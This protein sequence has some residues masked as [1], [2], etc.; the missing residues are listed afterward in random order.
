LSECTRFLKAIYCS[1]KKSIIENIQK[2]EGWG[3]KLRCT[4][5]KIKKR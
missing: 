1:E 3:G 5:G 2:K 4:K